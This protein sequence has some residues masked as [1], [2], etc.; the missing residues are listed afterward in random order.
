L[1]ARIPRPTPAPRYYYGLDELRA[2]HSSPGQGLASLTDA[3]INLTE[4]ELS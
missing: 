1:S 4:G 2:A 3:L